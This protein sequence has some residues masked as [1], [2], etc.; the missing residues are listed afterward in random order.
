LQIISFS[1]IF[2]NF[3]FLVGILLRADLTSHEGFTT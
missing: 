1:C 2:E 3:G